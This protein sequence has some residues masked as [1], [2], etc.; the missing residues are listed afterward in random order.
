[1]EVSSV[2]QFPRQ[3]SSG[4]FPARQPRTR[5]LPPECRAWRDTGAFGWRCILKRARPSAGVTDLRTAPVRRLTFSVIRPRICSRSCRMLRGRMNRNGGHRRSPLRKTLSKDTL[6]WFRKVIFA[7]YR[8]W[9]GMPGLALLTVK[10]KAR[11][12]TSSTLPRRLALGWLWPADHIAK[13]RF[14]EMMLSF[15]RRFGRYPAHQFC[16]TSL[17]EKSLIP[18]A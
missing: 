2:A 11:V 14:L 6:S 8:F 17:A 15:S 9:T 16:C 4:Q 5:S 12:W 1:M 18:A 3:H 10:C 7:G 13:I